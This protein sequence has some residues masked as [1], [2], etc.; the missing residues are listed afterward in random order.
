MDGR[1]DWLV[2]DRVRVPVHRRATGGGRRARRRAWATG[3]QRRDDCFPVT[4]GYWPS[5]EPAQTFD[6]GVAVSNDA[7][8]TAVTRVEG[9]YAK[10]QTMDEEGDTD[11]QHMILFFLY[12]FVNIR[13]LFFC[14]LDK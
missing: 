11:Q 6:G 4:S 12:I 10:R 1:W 13:T 5:G 7:A 14:F 3:R 2:C 9:I 8:D